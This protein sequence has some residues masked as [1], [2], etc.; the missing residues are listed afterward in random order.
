MLNIIF[1][2]TALL[3]IAYFVQLLLAFYNASQPDDKQNTI[4]LSLFSIKNLSDTWVTIGI[5]FLIP[6]AIS[7][8]SSIFDAFGATTSTD[9]LLSGCLSMLFVL[10]TLE[11]SLLRSLKSS[12][13]SWRG[14]IVFA[15]ALDLLS[16]IVL[17]GG[18]KSYL[19]HPTSA[20]WSEVV[21]YVQ[22]IGIAAFISSFC[23]V[24]FA[25]KADDDA[26]I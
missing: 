26:R 4:L 14:L 2:A 5:I 20:G 12:K 11:L 9:A 3:S 22:I 16:I 10:I 15:L 17:I 25:R 24:L 13:A 8:S 19:S 21:N 18:V 6:V 23:V 1:F 7:W